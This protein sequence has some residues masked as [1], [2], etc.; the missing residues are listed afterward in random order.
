MSDRERVERTAAFWSAG[1]YPRVAERLLPAALELV[2]AC[3]PGPGDRVLDVAAGTGNAALAAA[4]RG[5]RV[6]ASDITP[7]MIAL[8]RE[9]TAAAGLDAVVEWREADAQALPFADGAFDLTMSVF[10]AIFAP[11]PGRAAAELARVTRPGG[12][13]ALAAWTPGSINGRLGQITRRHLAQPAPAPGAAPEPLDPTLWGEPEVARRRLAPH[14]D[15]VDIASRALRWEFASSEA[16]M[17]FYEE[18]APPFVMARRATGDAYPAL[19]AELAALI[20]A[21]VEPGDAG[22]A[23]LSEWLLIRGRR[24]APAPR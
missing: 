9:R 23:I 15:R 19:R 8:G 20:A 13:V 1:D 3:A 22:I 14:C 4:E 11:D 18:S 6:T 12:T 21:E 5:A 24:P 16:A 17:A 2:A 7:T 10:G